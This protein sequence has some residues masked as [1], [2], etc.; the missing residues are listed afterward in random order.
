MPHTG[1]EMD[2]EGPVDRPERG[3]RWGRRIV[4]LRAQV[5]DGADVRVAGPESGGDVAILARHRAA[6]GAQLL[7]DLAVMAPPDQ[8]HGGHRD[9]QHHHQADGWPDDPP[10]F[11]TLHTTTLT[12]A[13]ATGLTFVRAIPRPDTVAE[14][15]TVWLSDD[16]NVT[17][18]RSIIR[19]YRCRTM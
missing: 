6:S 12:D 16:P 3:L 5:D 7:R 18:A 14:P 1:R 4:V 17:P 2:R 11:A 15:V 13:N 9:D 10:H 8:H 19:S